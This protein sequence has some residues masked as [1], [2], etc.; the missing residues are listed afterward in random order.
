MA[1]FIW[2]SRVCRINQE[3]GRTAVSSGVGGGGGLTGKWP[4]KTL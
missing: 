4:E 2:N 3:N 1:P